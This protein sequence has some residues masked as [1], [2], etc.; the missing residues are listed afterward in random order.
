MKRF[1][2]SLAMVGLMLPV[3]VWA[4]GGGGGF[5][6]G[7]RQPSPKMQLG[8]LLRDIGELEKA[9]K[10]PLTKE[11][12]KK[13]VAAIKP[14]EKK[15]KMTDEEAKALRKTIHDILTTAQK[16]ELDKMA[17]QNRR[18]GGGGPG[19]GGFGGGPGGFGGPGGGG[20][21]GGGGFGGGPGGFGGPGGGGPGG[22][23]GQPSPQQ[24]QQFRQTMQKMQ[25][26]FKIYNP[27]YPPD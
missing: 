12:A 18:M 5:G 20:P 2:V 19:G 8:R 4:Q 26:F 23:G 7:G 24:Q 1:V 14:W 13:I 22:G 17:A 3:S 6:G 25:E 9:N 27:F 16:N 15:P 21:G 11:Q 10:K